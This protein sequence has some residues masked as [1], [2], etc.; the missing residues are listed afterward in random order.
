M[1]D[2]FYPFCLATVFACIGDTEE[3]L[4]WLT[5]AVSW[6]FSNHRFLAEHNRFLAP[7]RGDPRLEALMEKARENAGSSAACCPAS[8]AFWFRSSSALET[9]PGGHRDSALATTGVSGLISARHQT[10]RI[11]RKFSW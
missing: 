11:L 5:Q 8:S 1:T 4:T 7:L 3:A 10:R 6:G 2:Q 9:S